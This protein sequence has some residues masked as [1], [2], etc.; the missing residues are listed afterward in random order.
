MGPLA[1]QVKYY[2]E[3]LNYIDIPCL[4]LH[5]KQKQ[6]KR[7]TTFFEFC[8]A[9]RAILLCTDVAVSCHRARTARSRCMQQQPATV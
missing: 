2:G 7:T 3:L 6:H 9:E 4:D 8:N 1:A 5:G